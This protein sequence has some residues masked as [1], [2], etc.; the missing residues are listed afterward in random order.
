MFVIFIFYYR[1]D[2]LTNVIYFEKRIMKFAEHLSAHV[3]PEW[4]SQYIRYDEMKELLAQ[5]V[6]KAQ[7]FVDESDNI[8][9]EQFFLRVDEHFFQVKYS[10]KTKPFFFVFS[11]LFFSIVKKKQ[12]KL[13]LFLQKNLLSKLKYILQRL[14]MWK[15]LSDFSHSNNNSQD[16][17]FIIPSMIL[18]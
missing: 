13:I 2:L 4:N 15:I 3:T 11:F 9:R 14:M 10:H 7:P 5:A 17:V 6:A 1:I 16:I 8:L 18:I 12:P